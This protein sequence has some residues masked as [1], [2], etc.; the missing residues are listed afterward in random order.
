VEEGERGDG[1]GAAA[2]VRQVATAARRIG[3]SG[4]PLGQSRLN[5]F[6]MCMIMARPLCCLAGAFRILVL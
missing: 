5:L 2:S 6:P 1:A 3:V 4:E